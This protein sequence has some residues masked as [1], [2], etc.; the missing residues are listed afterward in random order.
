MTICLFIKQTWSST[1]ARN[2]KKQKSTE[3]PP[4]R[5]LIVL[6]YGFATNDWCGV[7]SR[8]MSESKIL[9]FSRFLLSLSKLYNR[10]RGP[11]GGDSSLTHECAQPCQ[12][13]RRI[14]DGIR[15]FFKCC[16]KRIVRCK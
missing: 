16:V 3:A 7:I 2:P 5:K 1:L 10:K 15:E 14:Q 9:C 6:D 13:M 12:T 11:S 8:L 4:T